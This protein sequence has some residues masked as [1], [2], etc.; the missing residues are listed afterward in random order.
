MPHAVLLF[1]AITQQLPPLRYG[2]SPWT[3]K[4]TLEATL[5]PSERLLRRALSVRADRATDWP[6]I[7]S[8][9]LLCDGYSL[10]A[11]GARRGKA[12]SLRV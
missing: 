11:F 8:S 2:S 1:A 3:N 9:A 7:R 4:A 6:A 5:S 10:T 12:N